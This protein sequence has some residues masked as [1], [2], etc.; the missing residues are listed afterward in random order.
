MST[1]QNF[2]LYLDLLNKEHLFPLMENILLVTEGSQ[3]HVTPGKACV[4]QQSD[5]LITLHLI[6]IYQNEAKAFLSKVGGNNMLSSG[7]QNQTAWIKEKSWPDCF[8]LGN[9]FPLSMQVESIVCQLKLISTLLGIYDYKW[10][11]KQESIK[12][13]W[14]SLRHL[15]VRLK[16]ELDLFI[17]CIVG[18]AF[19]LKH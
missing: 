16:A 7:W 11:L 15:R 14:D 3:S 1:R 19:N 5:R 12:N 18:W 6:D 13:M 10:W 2:T 17:R 8:G 4:N 9:A